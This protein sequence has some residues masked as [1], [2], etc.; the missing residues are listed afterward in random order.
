MS[1][2][3]RGQQ[4]R[5]INKA[6]KP[7]QQFHRW[8]IVRGDLVQV[9]A[10][11]DKGKTGVVQK[12]ERNANRLYV[13]GLNLAKKH[14][15]ATADRKGGRILKPMPIP[16]SNLALVDPETGNPTKI[17]RKFITKEVDGEEAF[18]KVRVSK[19]TGN[20]IARPEILTERKRAVR[21]GG[22]KD[23]SLEIAQRVT[24][25]SVTDLP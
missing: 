20:I 24:V 2:G 11:K 9:T 17:H 10:G 23:T 22:A 25:E 13:Q 19:K 5:I 18:E 8:N 16:Y 21:E 1:A 7:E 3:F 12:V 14:V 4:R 15:R 6:L